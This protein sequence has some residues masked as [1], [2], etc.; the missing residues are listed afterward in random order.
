MAQHDLVV[1]W[2]V[3]NKHNKQNQAQHDLVVDWAVK[4]KHNKQNQA[5]HDLVVDWAVK[6]QH[7]QTKSSDICRSVVYDPV[8]LLYI[9]KSI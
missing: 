8:I 1:D 6:N 4:N 5:Q 9:L 3:K 2:A 7:K